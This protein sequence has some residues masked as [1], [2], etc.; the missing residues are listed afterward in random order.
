M[1]RDQTHTRLRLAPATLLVL[2]AATGCQ[3]G[4]GGLF[5]RWRASRDDAFVS[6]STREELAD[7]RGFFARML[8][9]AGGVGPVGGKRPASTVIAG[10]DGWGPA[11]EAADKA[12][13]AELDA[14]EQLFR[15]GKLP[16]AEVAYAKIAKK[17]KETVYGERA[18]YFVAET[19]YQRNHLVKA[20]DSFETL[21]TT[22]PSTRYMDKA[23]ARVYEIAKTWLAYSEGKAND[24]DNAKGEAPELHFWQSRFSGALPAIDVSGHAIAALDHVRARDA[25]GPLADDAVLRI[26]EYYHDNKDYE[27]AGEHYDQLVAENPKSPFVHKARLASIDSKMKAYLGPEYDGT[28]LEKANEAI[29]QTLITF[30]DRQA[31]TTDELMHTQDLIRDQRAERAFVHAKYYKEAGAIDS[32]EFYYAMIVKR[33]PESTWATKAKVQLASLAKAPRKAILP[34]KIMTAPGSDSGG[35]GGGM[36]GMQGMQAGAN[37]ING[38]SGF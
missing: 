11:R 12:A 6:N 4:S 18:Q 13:E 26:A 19:Q 29:K 33:W 2:V 8:S 24:K 27:S 17:Y 23:T 9:P 7:N 28:G 1:S 32:A 3:A 30:P 38:G 14:A 25:T 21:L 5:S 10:S 35:P 37:G 22:Y 20:N 31:G 34:S 16:E 36:G 15:R